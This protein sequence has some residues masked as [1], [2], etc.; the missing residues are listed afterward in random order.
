MT[1]GLVSAHWCST[2]R[3]AD[4]LSC[5]TLPR[6]VSLTHTSVF[7]TSGGDRDGASASLYYMGPDPPTSNCQPIAPSITTSS[8]FNPSP[9]LLLH[10]KHL[11]SLRLVYCV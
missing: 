11:P 8:N 4:P 5:I 6:L 7:Y 2:P 3:Y 9:P 10:H 1:R